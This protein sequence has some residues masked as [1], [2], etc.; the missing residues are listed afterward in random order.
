MTIPL[1]LLAIA[2]LSNCTVIDGDTLNCN[3]E[4]IRL[5]GIDAPEFHCPKNRV[6]VEGDPQAATDYLARIIQGHRLTIDRTGKDRYDR[7]LGVVYSD[8]LNVSCAMVQAGHAVYVPR[9]DDAG[10][11]A[12]DC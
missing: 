6:C 10:R 1:A 5:L 4:R 12:K 7:T 9:W 3:G 11:V 2:S 8:G